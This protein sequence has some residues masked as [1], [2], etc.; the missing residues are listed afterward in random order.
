MACLLILVPLGAVL[1]F[2][3]SSLQG[4]LIDIGVVIG[5]LTE[6]LGDHLA[7]IWP[8]VVMAPSEAEAM[9]EPDWG[10]HQRVFVGALIPLSLATMWIWRERQWFR[11]RLRSEIGVFRAVYGAP[12]SSESVSASESEAQAT[13]RTFLAAHGF[14][15]GAVELDGSPSEPVPQRAQASG[16]GGRSTPTT[17]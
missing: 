7:P 13:A 9:R 2:L 10:A 11:A 14:C 15:L 17:R 8:L 5:V 16:R 4:S 6:P 1:G 3:V 12:R